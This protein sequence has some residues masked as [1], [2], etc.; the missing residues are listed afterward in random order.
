MGFTEGSKYTMEEV[1]A[2][3][4]NEGL[5]YAIDCWLT[6]ENIEDD[7]LRELCMQFKEVRQQIKDRM[8]EELGE[9][10]CAG[11]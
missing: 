7:K 8:E 11:L 10:A 3:M 1:K 9:D 4:I 2:V 6:L 5:D